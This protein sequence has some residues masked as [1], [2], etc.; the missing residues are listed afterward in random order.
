[1]ESK[2]RKERKKTLECSTVLRR[3][4]REGYCAQCGGVEGRKVNRKEN[5]G[6]AW[7]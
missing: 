6:N 3:W 5:K 4:E 7:V 1:M 2:K